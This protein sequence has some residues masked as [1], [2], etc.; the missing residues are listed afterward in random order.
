MTH[1]KKQTSPLLKTAH[2]MACSLYEVGAI[3]AITLREYDALSFPPVKSFTA[4][5]I[6][7]IRIHE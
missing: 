1:R 5:D 7:R 2:D 6:K 3:S 4:R